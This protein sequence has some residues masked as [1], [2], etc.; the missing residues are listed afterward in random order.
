MQQTKDIYKQRNKF[1]EKELKE[2]SILFLAMNNLDI[3]RKNIELL[4][5][6]TFSG[7]LINEFKQKLLDYLLSE[8]FF[9]RKKLNSKD[10]E[11]KFQ[12]IIDQINNNAPIKIIY[13][14]KDE[15]EIIVMFNEIVGEIKKIELEKKIDSLEHKVSLN[16]DENLYTELLSLRNQLKRG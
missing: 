11:E 13:K 7:K 9:D 4:S 1:E 16:L 3:F 5:E 14:N 12:S 2:Y 8:E 10:F 6:I 15:N